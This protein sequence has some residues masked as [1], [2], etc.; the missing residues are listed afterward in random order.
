MT[1]L[2]TIHRRD[3]V[4]PEAEPRRA[5]A[6]SEGGATRIYFVA[7][8]SLLIHFPD[9]G[10]WRNAIAAGRGY[11]PTPFASDAARQ[12]ALDR[13]LDPALFTIRWS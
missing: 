9:D 1:P 10:D 2:D 3:V 12:M 7:M 13:K 5:V 6:P 4:A 11:L 8:G